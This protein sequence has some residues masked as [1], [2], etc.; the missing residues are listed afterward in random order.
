MFLSLCFAATAAER[1][2]YVYSIDQLTDEQW[3]GDL[4][5]WRSEG[6]QRLM[7]SME[8]GPRLLL[9]DQTQSRRVAERLALANL[10]GFRVEA[11]IL[12]DPSWALLPQ[13]AR[14]RLRVVIGFAQQYPGLLDAVQIDVEV[15]TPSAKLLFG[16]GEAWSRFAIL[17]GVLRE[18][19]NGR[20]QGL[21]LTAAVP[22]WLPYGPSPDEL[23]RIREALDGF[24][25]MVYRDEGG[26]PVAADI[27]TFRGK[28]K[29]AVEELS[30]RRPSI[31]VGVAKYE[32]ASFARV[33]GFIRELD[34]LLVATPGYEGTMIFHDG[35]R[36]RSPAVQQAVAQADAE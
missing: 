10:Q 7:V 16:E 4:T 1:S 8:S 32:H 12:Q 30:G 19:M 28:V 31:V 35:S 3:A 13:E 6:I 11:M 33:A 23:R 21:R 22:W 29:P 20:N 15:Y 26:T 5:R 18:E 34:Q 9:A 27:E 36:Y 14:E 24:R 25:L 2:V 17:V